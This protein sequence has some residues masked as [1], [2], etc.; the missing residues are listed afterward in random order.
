MHVLP[1]ETQFTRKHE[2]FSISQ[3]YTPQSVRQQ[4]FAAGF[5]EYLSLFPED[6]TPNCGT[7]EEMQN[8]TKKSVLLL[9]IFRGPLYNDAHESI[10]E[11]REFV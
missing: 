4:R 9:D 3:D 5:Q 2:P 7:G 8:N 1:P 11:E 10:A 6:D